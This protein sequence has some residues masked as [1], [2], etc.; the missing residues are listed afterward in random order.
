MLSDGSTAQPVRDDPLRRRRAVTAFRCMCH[1]L[2]H[3]QNA[4]FGTLLSPFH[5]VVEPGVSLVDYIERF[6]RQVN[7]GEEGV[8]LGMI[9]ATRYCLAT[10]MLPSLLSMHRLLVI[11][12]RLG[13]KAHHDIFRSNRTYAKAS[14]LKLQEFNDLERLML[15]GIDFRVVVYNT[16]MLTLRT[17]IRRIATGQHAAIAYLMA[18]ALDP[19]GSL[20]TVSPPELPVVTP[21]STAHASGA[22]SAAARNIRQEALSH[23]NSASQS[24]LPSLMSSMASTLRSTESLWLSSSFDCGEAPSPQQ[25]AP[26]HSQR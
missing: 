24:G 3:L 6:D 7:C 1:H 20:L 12:T 15:V 22:A 16:E 25:R 26:S 4:D 19:E 10:K 5:S 9:I 21:L 13:V 23:R 2:S 8:L 14:G 18:R 11:A 17:A